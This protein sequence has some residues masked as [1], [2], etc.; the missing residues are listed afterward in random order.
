MGIRIGIDLGTTFSAAAM[1]DKRKGVPVIIP[2][3][4]GERITPSVIQFQSG[5]TIVGSEAKE[6]YEAGESGC[7]SS[8]KRSMGDDSAYCTIGGQSYTP[9]HLSAIMLRHIK[10][11]VEMVT[12]EKVDEAVITVPA[13][14][15]HRE[16]SATLDAAR[17]AGLNVKQLINEP[18]AAALAYSVDHWRENARIMVYDLGGGTFDVTLIEMKSGGRV[19]SI[20]TTGDHTLGGKDWDARLA[21]LIESKAEAEAGLSVREYPSLHNAAMRAAE[22]VKKQLSSR[23][24]AA[25]RLSSEDFGKYST[26]VTIDEFNNATLDLIKRTTTLCEQLLSELSLSWSGITDIL[27]VGGST[28]MRQVS[29]FLKERSGH[30]P[31]M[32]VN[33]DEAVALGAAIS[34]WSPPPE[35][36][37]GVAG[38]I[39]RD[40]PP[41]SAGKVGQEQKL[42]SALSVVSSDVCAHAM[43]VIAV[44]A[45]GSRYINKTIVPDNSR[46]PV[47]C[48]ESFHYYTSEGGSNELEIYMLQGEKPPLES[49]VIGKYTVSGITHDPK[50][51]PAVVSIQYSYD[52][53]G[54]V[55]VQVRR[56]GR[57]VDLPVKEETVPKDM[58]KFGNP[59][60]KVKVTGQP[61]RLNVVMAV[62][63][64]GSMNGYPL[65]EAKKAMCH[66]VDKLR[67]YPNN[68]QA[69]VVAVS[70]RSIVVM[71][72]GSDMNKCKAAI[73]SI[74]EEMAGVLNG[75]DPFEDIRRLLRNTDGKRWGIVLADGRW[76]D[77]VKAV[78]RA[79]MC[80]EEGIDIVGIGFG[81]ADEKFLHDI[82]SGEIESMFV[83]QDKLVESF[84]KIAREIG[85]AAPKKTGRFDAVTAV[86]TW[87]ATDESGGG[88]PLTGSVHSSR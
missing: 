18:T 26:E 15:Y 35:Y 50:N 36:N 46:I 10:D 68:P 51:N 75:A 87:R 32:H 39:S 70:D 7:T 77:Q 65:K 71:K 2:N 25:V 80:H 66:F 4:E 49:E 8:F 29:S 73:N 5:R 48:A 67:Q 63:V 72:L 43:G 74:E 13:Y 31:L 86:S 44:S 69:G 56:Q 83:S 6:A 1:M 45:D 78:R 82:S 34:V 54:L 88:S 30:S 76:D 11:E 64:S 27:L 33:P 41:K 57:D 40:K 58:S 42:Q 37:E 81:T 24:T 16:R 3:S 55:H 59:P 28:R 61:Q 21:G 60:E 20:R 52:R 12:G 79:R 9:V 47:K 22:S 19:E 53:S 38:A 84:G 62:D 85:S 14:F 17:L 23:N